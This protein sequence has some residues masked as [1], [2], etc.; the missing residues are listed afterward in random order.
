MHLYD[1]VIRF[2]VSL[3]SIRKF[4]D[5]KALCL[6]ENVILYF[7]VF[8]MSYVS[9]ILSIINSLLFISLYMIKSVN[10]I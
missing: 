1:T 4:C 8:A 6:F 7:T 9:V 2:D 10:A 3:P 5:S